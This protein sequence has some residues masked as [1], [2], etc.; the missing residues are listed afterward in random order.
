MEVICRQANRRTKDSE[1]NI[2][3]QIQRENQ[4]IPRRGQHCEHRADSKVPKGQ[5]VPTYR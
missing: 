2:P 3:L 5:N 1:T 4:K